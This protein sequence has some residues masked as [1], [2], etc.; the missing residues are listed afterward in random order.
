LPLAEAEATSISASS[1]A[2]IFF[3]MIE[4]PSLS[5][6]R[7]DGSGADTFFVCESSP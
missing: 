5:V 7:L 4:R 3:N 6:L 1:D 2:A